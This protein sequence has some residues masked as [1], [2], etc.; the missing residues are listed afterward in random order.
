[1]SHA[2][3]LLFSSASSPETQFICDS[4]VDDSD[5]QVW[6]RSYGQGVCTFCGGADR[7]V[8]GFDAFIYRLS[9]FFNQYFGH[10]VDQL[11]HDSEAESGYFGATFDTDDVLEFFEL[12][13][14]NDDGEGTLRTLICDSFM[15]DE[16]WCEFDWLRLPLGA[17]LSTS[18]ERFV[19]TVKHERRFYFHGVRATK[20]LD[21][22]DQDS[23][24]PDALLTLVINR[25]I[26]VEVQK[27]H[28]YFR[29]RPDD[30]K[31]PYLTGEELGPPPPEFAL[32]SN[33]MNPP[34]IPMMYCADSMQCAIAEIGGLP[35]YIGTFELARDIRILDLTSLPNAPGLLSDHDRNEREAML[36]IR[37]FVRS[38]M[39][40]VIRDREPHLDYIPSQVVSEFIRDF[41][42]RGGRLDGI[43]YPSLA[44]QGGMSLV[45]FTNESSIEGAAP[46]RW[47]RQKPLFKLVSAIRAP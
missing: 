12:N 2:K 22:E 35:A 33:R 45:F 36:F 47:S 38:I 46:A 11:P 44:F 34:G 14:P 26:S 31:G 20:S 19:R 18:W 16:P 9:G 21:E 27:G 41:D 23:W 13:F 7:S 8:A 5:L 28:Q 25:C 29:A 1:M 24:T 42:F 3:E 40:P 15:A 43:I 6:I 17:A 37:S 39:Q 30:G 4:C 32:Q 10:A